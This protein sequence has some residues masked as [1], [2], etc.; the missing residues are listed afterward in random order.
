VFRVLTDALMHEE[1]LSFTYQKPGAAPKRHTNVNPLVLIY[2]GET[3]ELL[4]TVGFDATMRR[5]PL[6]RIQ[7]PERLTG[8]RVVRPR[9]FDVDQWLA[10]GGMGVPRNGAPR[11]FV[12]EARVRGPRS[13]TLEE[14]PYGK[15]QVVTDDP[16]GWKRLRVTVNNSKRPAG[17]VLPG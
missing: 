11:T 6:R 14:A 8:L 5:F 12:L 7:D 3:P 13:G 17:A 16:D 1:Q 4:A 15:D 9:D 10:D 2:W